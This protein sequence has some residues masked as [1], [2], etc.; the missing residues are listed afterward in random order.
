MEKDL[1]RKLTKKRLESELNKILNYYMAV[2]DEYYSGYAKR[3]S[4][5]LKDLVD[6]LLGISAVLEVYVT[7][8]GIEPGY[9]IEKLEFTQRRVQSTINYFERKGKKNASSN[10]W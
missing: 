6:G 2:Y 10:D 3:D 4:A 7:Q 8:K 1:C 5:F 9:A